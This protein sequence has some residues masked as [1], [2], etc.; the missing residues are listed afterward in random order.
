VNESGRWRGRPA[1]PA[2]VVA[3][4]ALLAAA[5]LSGA[6]QGPGTTLEIR[7][8]QGSI[9][10]RVPLGADGAFTLRYR[11]S[12][13]GT[14]A[15]ERFVAAGG[16]LK[17]QELAA[18]QLAVLEEYYAVTERP[19]RD[20]RGWWHAP[21]AYELELQSLTVAA[22]DLGRR[23][24]RVAGHGPVELWRLVSDAAPSVELEMVPS[25]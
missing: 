19:T 17:L 23:T 25:R 9:L 11:N 21:P 22:T 14:V 12:L 8:G 20:V 15:E 16:M 24:L 4:G 1:G 5:S 2:V 18:R 10:A 13:Y 3:L 7:D 6:D